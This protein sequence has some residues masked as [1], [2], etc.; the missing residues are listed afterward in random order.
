M[1]AHSRSAFAAV[2]RVIRAF[3]EPLRASRACVVVPGLLIFV[4]GGPLAAQRVLPVRPLGPV[5]H[6]SPADILGSVSV[7]RPLPGGRVLVSDVTRRQVVLLDADFNR[8]KTVIDSATGAGA[9][10][11][12]PMSGLIPFKSESSLV[13]DPRTLTML[14]IDANGDVARVMAVPSVRDVPQMVG[15]PFGSPGYDARGRVVFRGAPSDA[16][17]PAGGRRGSSS[18]VPRP[19]KADS[20]PILRVELA[21]RKRE[22][23]GYVRIPQVLG[24]NT[25]DR[26]D[27]L[28]GTTLI[29]NPLP[30]VDD[31]ALMPDGR[32]A[33]VRGSDYHVDWLGLDG[34]WT[35]TGRIPFTWERLDDEA[36]QRVVDSVM[37]Q[38]KLREE[39]RRKLEADALARSASSNVTSSRNPDVPA[40]RQRFDVVQVTLLV[41]PANQL[42]DYRP[43][44]GQGAVRADADGNLWV[45]T[46]TPTAAGPIYDVINASGELV[47][48]VRLPFG[49]V[50]AGFGNG[51]VYMGVLDGNNARLEMARVK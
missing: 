28:A 20:A 3:R 8:V 10:L 14:V 9:F 51:V 25:I 32:V 11:S 39:G 46:T 21:T 2:R 33:V 30:T 34:R 37:A 38:E 23:L 43:P 29:V 4:V 5:T 22:V 13:I 40:A 15:G 48:R 18:A 1:L 26:T 7:V 6:V 35:S 24:S 47:D 45:R 16:A 41:V 19:I 50:I 17:P 49:R 27:R 42:P 44:F 31:W 36:K 12:G